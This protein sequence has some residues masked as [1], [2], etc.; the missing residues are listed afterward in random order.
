MKIQRLPRNPI[1]SPK[2]FGFI[3]RF[4]K[5]SNINGPTLIKVPNWIK[6]PLGK[7]YLYFA[8]HGGKYI[9]LAYSD[10]IEGPYNLY[11]LGTLHN[12]GDFLKNH[13]IAS[14]EI[15][16]DKDEEKIY[17]F[18]H[19]N[20]RGE[21]PYEDQGQMTFLATSKNG[22]DF[23]PHN[24]QLAPFYLRVFKYQGYFYGIAKNDNMDAV[25]VRS[26]NPY[27][28][29]ERGK[30]FMPRFRH[31]ALL[32]RDDLLYVFFSRAFDKP[33][34]ILLSTMKLK[35]NW[36]EWDLSKPEI[37]LKPERRWEG[38]YLPI[39]ESKYGGTHATHAL[40][41][42]NI[43]CEGNKVYLLYTVKGEKGIAISEILDL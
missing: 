17:M 40:R 24:Q 43:Y 31:C 26:K 19:A 23:T 37:V 34:V 29:F 6:N 42:P 9:R 13:H 38:S 35:Q 20:I 28:K 18:F 4:T 1:I 25:L 12:T 16:I 7:Y 39:T 8:N 5:G 11:K 22:I 14:P 33:E 21:V 10:N 32:R 27:N 15:Y 41:D 30:Q 2:M 3:G 36:E